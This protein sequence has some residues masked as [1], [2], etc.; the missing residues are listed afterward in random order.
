MNIIQ[1]TA[2]EFHNP[3]QIYTT[4]WIDPRTITR[5]QKID[6]RIYDEVALWTKQA[7]LYTPDSLTMIG[8]TYLTTVAGGSTFPMY[9]KETP[10]ELLEQINKIY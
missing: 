7:K 5:F 6:K 2:V 9:L 4:V 8:G 10:Q 3:D 1:L